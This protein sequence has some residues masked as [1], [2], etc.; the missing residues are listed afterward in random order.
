MGAVG[1]GVLG[2]AA[3]GGGVLVLDGA[4]ALGLGAGG[5]GVIVLD[6]AGEGA[7]GLDSL[8]GVGVGRGA[9]LTS[10]V[11]GALVTVGSFG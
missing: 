7:L 10:G 11:R 2:F 5:G 6:G 9:G 4:G 1:A 3:G 8:S